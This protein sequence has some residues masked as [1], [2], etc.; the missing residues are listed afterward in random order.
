MPTVNIKK[1]GNLLEK[2]VLSEFAPGILRGT[3]VELFRSK[4]V[5]VA[6]ATEWVEGNYSLWGRLEPKH[7]A[8]IK[9][10]AD[11]MGDTSW[12]TVDWAIKALRHDC[13][14]LASLFLG[15][16]KAHNW[17]ERQLEEIRNQ[18]RQ[19]GA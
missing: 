13:P 10:F 18:V 1:L 5:D 19:T 11:K 6:K 4:N 12:V 2:G 17:L 3:L 16:R 7:R 9:R 15:W 14:S 8:Q